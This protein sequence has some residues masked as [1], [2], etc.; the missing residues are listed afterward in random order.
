VVADKPWVPDGTQPPPP[1]TLWDDP[2]SGLV[3]GSTFDPEPISIDLAKPV[4][5]DMD[6]VRRAVDAAMAKE[7][8]FKPAPVV[9]APRGEL[10]A[11]P[12]DTPGGAPPLQRAGWPRM[13]SV[14]RIPGFRP[15]PPAPPPRIQR[16]RRPGGSPGS[17]LAGVAAVVVVAGLVLVIILTMISSLV[18]TVSSFFN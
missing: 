14:Q 7:D 3:T 9:P 11:P 8:Q 1:P 5:P 13:P 18:N 16:V 6:E 2:V 4:E 12:A 15:R 17:R 10:P